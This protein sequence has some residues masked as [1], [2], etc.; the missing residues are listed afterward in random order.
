MCL[1]LQRTPIQFIPD[2]CILGLTSSHLHSLLS[3]GSTVMVELWL[4]S[5]KEIVVDHC[6]SHSRSR[7]TE[8]RPHPAS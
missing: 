8:Q 2:E 7:A 3:F 4:T 1:Q 6:I 5:L